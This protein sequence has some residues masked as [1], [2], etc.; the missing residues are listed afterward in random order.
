M[1]TAPKQTINAPKSADRKARRKQDLLEKKFHVPKP[2]RTPVEQPPVIVAVVGPPQ[3]G[4][5]TLIKSLVKYYTRHGLSTANG[6]ITIVS[7]KKRRITLIECNNDLHSM[8]DVAKVA[9]LVLLMVDASFGFEM[10]LFE[11]LN[12]C[13]SHGFPKIMAI[14]TH[15]DEL[16]TEAEKKRAKKSMKKRFWTEIY[17]GAKL[18]FC[19]GVMHGVYGKR[20]TQNIARYVSVMKYRPL[21]WQ[22][23]H[24]YVLVDRMEDLTDPELVRRDRAIDRRVSMY[25]FVRGLPLLPNSDVHIPGCGDFKLRSLSKISDPCPLPKKTD[26]ARNSLNQKERM[27]YAPFCGVGGVLCDKDAVYIEVAGAHSF[28]DRIATHESDH[29]VNKILQSSETMDHKM[30]VSKFKFFSDETYD[31]FALVENDGILYDDDVADDEDIVDFQVHEGTKKLLNLPILHEPKNLN[32]KVAQA[33]QVEEEREEEEIIPDAPCEFIIDIHELVY[34]KKGFQGSENSI[35]CTLNHN[36]IEDSQCKLYL[37]NDKGKDNGYDDDMD[38]EEFDGDEADDD[39]DDA[40]GDEDEDDDDLDDEAMDEFDNENYGDSS[41]EQP[42]NQ[43]EESKHRN[44][45]KLKK[46]QEFDAQYDTGEIK[47]QEKNI[48]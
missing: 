35:E 26:K 33:D 6:P 12:I 13:Q 46:K 3:V 31:N 45:L 5:T 16:K 47:P 7:G 19:S 32:K 9:D 2:D 28:A 44:L 1:P 21:T 37:K 22:T 42:K 15:L 41:D 23:N 27:I 40:D 4:K 11:F 39:C 34:G 38:D 30:D 43:D 8:L 17:K 14:L 29:I 36:N 25:G 10:E 18:F 20:D 24:P 48:L